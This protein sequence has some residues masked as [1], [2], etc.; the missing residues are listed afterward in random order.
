MKM[1]DAYRSMFKVRS[2]EKAIADYYFNNKIFSFV[3][4]YIGQEAVAVGVSAALNSEDRVY[5][6]HRSHGHYLAKGGDLYH[7]YAEMLGKADGCC[8]GK[9]GSMHMLDREVGFMGSTPILSSG[10]PISAGSAFEQ[11]FNNRDGLTVVYVGD[12]A[13]EEGEFYE[14]LNLAALYELPLLVVV[15]NN[16]YSVNSPASS[17]KSDGFNLG[18]VVSGLGVAY[19][20][21]NGNSYNEVEAAAAAAAAHVRQFRKP[22]VL[23]CRVFRHMAHSAPISDDHIGY[24]LEDTPGVRD[25]QDSVRNLRERLIASNGL[26]CVESLEIEVETEVAAALKRAVSAPYPQIGELFTD[27]YTD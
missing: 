3:H 5:G 26:N 17:R 12:G 16:L 2:A 14:T 6:N 22:A 15:E 21:A 1:L 13:S 4:F 25:E 23:S 18:Q 7:M 19:F 8:S 24:R 27:V 11:K 10:V 20:D 9:G